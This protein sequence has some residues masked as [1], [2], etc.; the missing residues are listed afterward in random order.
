MNRIELES[1]PMGGIK[2]VIGP[3][4]WKI[5]KA[6]GMKLIVMAVPLAVFL[7]YIAFFAVE[8]YRSESIY[9]IRD[10]ATQQSLGVDLSLFGGGSSSS[11]LDS[12]IVVNYLQSMD[13]FNRVDRWFNLT[14]RYRS[15]KT[16][17]L[18]RLIFNP[19]A[20]DY[21]DLFRKNLKI[22]SDE[23]SGITTIS[24]DCSDP[25]LAQSILRYLL[26]AG[27]AFLN[28]LNHNTAEK[29]IAFLTEQLADNKAK[30]DDAVQAMEVF[31]NK[32]RLVDPSASLSTYHNIIAGIEMEIAKKT[33]EYNQLLRY[34]SPDTMEASKL[35]NE[36]EEQKAALDKM[37]NRLS[38][39]E[40]QHLNDLIFEYQ[41]LQ[42]VV[43]F[44]SEVYKNTLVQYEMN[45]ME[46]LQESKVFEVIAVPSLPDGH[47]YPKRI[48]MTLTAIVL[49]F[50]FYRVVMLVWIVIRD[51]KD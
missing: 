31:Q 15:E 41:R 25:E 49:I 18:D 6:H 36:I 27:E 7:I 39:P 50:L 29:K 28:Q 9:V 35:K 5:V 48:R 47:V 10:L 51:H 1:K 30:W 14:A 43:D 3:R 24:F 17:I 4:M 44:A 33:S 40:K 19:T 20:E 38:G 22:V 26:T 32:H 12:K 2:K 45:K 21:L 37:K 11:Q 16:D 8:K 34:M 13:I 23:A 46:A 42:S